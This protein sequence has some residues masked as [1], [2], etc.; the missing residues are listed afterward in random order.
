LLYHPKQNPEGEGASPAAK[1]FTGKFL[2]K[3][4]WIFTIPNP[5]SKGKKAPDPG[6]AALNSS[7]KFAGKVYCTE[8]VEICSLT[9]TGITL[10]HFLQGGKMGI[11][12]A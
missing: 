6:S 11:S 4:D 9:K 7:A 8:G 2:R 3:A 1:S 12:E 5:R 10:V